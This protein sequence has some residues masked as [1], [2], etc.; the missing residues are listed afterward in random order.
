M[1]LQAAGAGADLLRERFAARGVSLAE[2]QHV[3]RQQ[4]EGLQHAGDVPG[5]R[6]DG[7]GFAAFGRAGAAADERGQP[8]GQRGGDLLGADE[9]HVAVDAAGGEDLAVAGDDLGGGPDHQVGVDVGVHVRV[10]GFADAGDPAVADADVGFD[11]APVVQDHRAG[12]DH[13][14]GA[15][16][17]GGH[18]LAHGFAHDLAAA[19][20][21]FVAGAAG[22]SA[23]VFGD[24]DEQVGVGEP[25][26][27]AGGRPEQFDVLAAVHRGAHRLP[28][29]LSP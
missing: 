22:A 27:V 19:E 28:S 25:D 4:V 8:G 15:F 13:V 23:A 26:A 11:D 3:D 29:P 16:G 12:D 5:A 20:D 7:G 10:A 2:Q 24:F 6:G 1:Q 18:R 14:R 9:V 21:D 17:A